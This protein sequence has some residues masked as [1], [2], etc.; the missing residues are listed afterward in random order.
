MTQ[1]KM[2]MFPNSGVSVPTFLMESSKTRISQFVEI[3]I[4]QKGVL[5]TG[6]DRFNVQGITVSSILHFKPIFYIDLD[7]GDG[8]TVQLEEIGETYSAPSNRMT[9]EDAGVSEKM[10]GKYESILAK[11]EDMNNTI[12]EHTSRAMGVTS[13]KVNY[14]DPSINLDGD[15]DYDDLGIEDEE[16]DEDDEEEETMSV[17]MIEGMSMKIDEYEKKIIDSLTKVVTIT[18]TEGD[19]GEKFTSVSLSDARQMLANYGYEN[20]G[21]F[22]ESMSFSMKQFIESLTTS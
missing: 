21:F 10:I 13:T 14:P 15:E 18:E 16:D 22:N 8:G 11:C 20:L 7:D 5:P 19:E 3:S 9:L 6:K 17:E 2:T 12:D 1:L 4:E